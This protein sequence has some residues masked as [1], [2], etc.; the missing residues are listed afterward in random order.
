MQNHTTTE[1]IAFIQ[2]RLDKERAEAAFITLTFRFNKEIVD[3]CR[4]VARKWNYDN[5]VADLIAE[6]VFERFWKY[7]GGFKKGKCKTPNIDQCL[8]FYL[9]RT[10]RNC[11]FDYH[12]Q[13][14]GVN[15]S[16]YDGKESVVVAFPDLEALAIPEEKLE[17]LLELQKSMEKALARLSPKHKTIYLTYKAYEKEGYK[18]PRTL[19][20]KLR[21]ELSLSQNSI[22]VYKN[23]A[24]QAIEQLKL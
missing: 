1:L 13:E 10:A 15:Q 9:L 6:R 14:T 17:S 5:G 4:K 12:A 11:F 7:P 16:P 22:R 20:K 8:V 3:I 21:E 2:N 23:E 24:F 19:L 18:L